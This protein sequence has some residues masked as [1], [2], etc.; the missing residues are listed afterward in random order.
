ML[1]TAPIGDLE[2]TL[3]G[4]YRQFALREAQMCERLV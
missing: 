2:P 1:A 3:T 4:G